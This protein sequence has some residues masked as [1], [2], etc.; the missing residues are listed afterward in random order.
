MSETQETNSDLVQLHCLFLLIC[1]AV[2]SLSRLAVTSTA[3][4]QPSGWSSRSLEPHRLHQRRL[5]LS[6]P[7]LLDTAQ[8]VLTSCHS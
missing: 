4:W 5:Q 7:T 6:R 2:R 8:K 1:A 3:S